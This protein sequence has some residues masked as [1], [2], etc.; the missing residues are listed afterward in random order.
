LLETSIRVSSPVFK[1]SASNC[2]IE[3]EFKDIANVTCRFTVTNGTNQDEHAIK[4]FGHCID[5]TALSPKVKGQLKQKSKRFDKTS[6]ACLIK[7][8][9]FNVI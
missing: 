6:I 7:M 1:I 2:A 9:T 3:Q 5:Q 8:I 4:Y